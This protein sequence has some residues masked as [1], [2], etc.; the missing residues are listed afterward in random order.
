MLDTR[1]GKLAIIIMAIALVISCSIAGVA[2]LQ[3]KP[4]ENVEKQKI[5][6][7]PGTMFSMGELIVNLADTNE[8]HYLKTDIVLEIAGT[9]NSKSE[10]EEAALKAPLRD[11]I[12]GI[13]SSKRFAEL[14]C[15]DGK[16]RLKTELQEVCDN[17]LK[18][19]RVLNVY[20][21]EF[22]MQ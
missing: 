10:T 2:V 17:C 16:E 9:I 8:I 11:A 22:A 13:L 7:E 12:I 14:N 5:V 21:S 18:P 1:K 6:N 3:K 19:A 4:S 15:P 20:F